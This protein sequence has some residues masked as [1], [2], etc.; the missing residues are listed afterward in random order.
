MCL[1][2]SLEGTIFTWLAYYATGFVPATTA[3]LLLSTYLLA[4]IPARFIFTL[5]I[6][7]VPYLA[8]LLVAVAP[9]IPALVIV[10]SGANGLVL[11]A[12]VFVAGACISSGF[13][14]STAYAVD[15]APEYTGPLNALTN[16]AM[17]IGMSLA[18]ALVGV[19]GDLYGIQRALGLTVGISGA[20]IIT[21]VVM[22]VRTG[23]AN[24]PT[25]NTP[26]D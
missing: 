5:A 14:I 13:P 21:I 1:V 9:G 12:A 11:F 18:P 26:A 24:A 19:P 4:Y 8:L 15:A 20:L 2:G 3:N 6:D 22:V 10:F 17:Y 7:Y 23:T 25:A 16:G